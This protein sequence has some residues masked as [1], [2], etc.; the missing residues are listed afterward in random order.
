MKKEAKQGCDSPKRG[1][2]AASGNEGVNGKMIS[3][4][5]MPGLL[6]NLGKQK[7]YF[8][9]NAQGV[10]SASDDNYTHGVGSTPEEA[11]AKLWLA[12]HNSSQSAIL[13]INRDE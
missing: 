2:K 7:K 1:K 6:L 12:L 3:R 8:Q 5:P 11:V 13:K 4:T 10:W 9:H